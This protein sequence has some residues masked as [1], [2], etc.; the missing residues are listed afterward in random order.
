MIGGSRTYLGPILGGMIFTVLPE[1][2]RALG[3]TAGLPQWLG[4]FLKDGRLIIFGVMI[5]L[6]SIFFPRGF[7]TPEF[8]KGL[9]SKV[10]SLFR[11]KPKTN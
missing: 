2:L 5:V 10:R 7:I 6:G 1:L 4:D 9:E 8:A 3:D 11:R